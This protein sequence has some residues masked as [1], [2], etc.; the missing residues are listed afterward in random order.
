MRCEPV[1]R[2]DGR[3]MAPSR[4]GR[5]ALALV[6]WVSAMLAGAAAA[7]AV[8][9]PAVTVPS[10]AAGSQSV[11]ARDGAGRDVVAWLRG[12]SPDQ[13]AASTRGLGGAFSTSVLSSDDVPPLE[14]PVIAADPSGPVAIAWVAQPTT[15]G[16]PPS[17]IDYVI[18]TAAGLG[19]RQTIP[20]AM[21]GADPES[22]DVAVTPSETI[23]VWTQTIS[24]DTR[25]R[26]L[27]RSSSGAF[28]SVS[29]LSDADQD[30]SSPRV[31]A[32]ADGAIV[33]WLQSVEDTTTDGSEETTTNV[34]R[35]RVAARIPAG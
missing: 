10:S 15:P 2:S 12:G 33:T 27:I 35:V 23:F 18:G 25:V 21:T 30:A 29:A 26:A 34:T 1:M 17:Q 31:S 20:T 28:S 7:G 14:P 4:S 6:A 8:W 3:G 11:I 9:S 24:G 32:A 13:V 19:G 22:V 5:T 16:D